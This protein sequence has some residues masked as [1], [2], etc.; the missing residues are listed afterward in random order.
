MTKNI[1]FIIVTMIFVTI[2]IATVS[3][4]TQI[5]AP[6]AINIQATGLLTYIENLGI[7]VITGDV[8]EDATIT[9]DAPSGNNF[10]VGTT[11]V[12]WTAT[13]NS[14][15]SNSATQS[16]TIE[17]APIKLSIVN[18]NPNSSLIEERVP[19]QVTFSVTTNQP[20]NMLWRLD[21]VST[22]GGQSVTRDSFPATF[23]KIGTHTATV[24][25][26]NGTDSASQTWTWNVKG[27]LEASAHPSSINVGQPTNVT[28]KVDRRCGIEIGDDCTLLKRLPVSGASVSLTGIVNNGGVVNSTT[29]EFVILINTTTNGTINVTASKSGY[30]NGYTNI[31]VG[32]PTPVTTPGGSGSS[33]NSGSS[34]GGSSG[35]SMGGCGGGTAEPYENIYKYEVQEH[36]VSTIPVSFKYVSPELAVYEV[37][38]TS[39][40]SDIASLRIEVLKDASKLVG[41]PAP[42]IEYKNINAW[43]DYKRIKN[44]TIRFKVENSWMNNNGLSDNNIKMNKWDNN[45]KKC[46]CL[47][48]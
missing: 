13:D 22:T 7:P 31:S 33:G 40:Q 19:S 20:A 26:Q 34:S 35:G 23:D 15:N 1:L 17:P 2:G 44:A 32:V 47:R 48:F 27:T 36:T 4:Q 24:I 42:G 37:L 10:P 38:V 9:N 45:N 29:G 39:L 14:G 30:I 43:I 21:G 25:A 41:S 28:I 16:I 6:P 46:I 5:Q 11:I 3:G 12:T 8:P 18:Y